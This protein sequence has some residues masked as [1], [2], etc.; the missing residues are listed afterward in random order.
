[1]KI[2]T[3]SCWLW[4]HKFITRMLIKNERVGVYQYQEWLSKQTEFC[5]RC[6]IT[7]PERE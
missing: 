2:G 4:G 1:M 6:G 7:N 5:M 3:F